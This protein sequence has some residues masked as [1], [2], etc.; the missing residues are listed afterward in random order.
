VG[1]SGELEEVVK[2]LEAVGGAKQQAQHEKAARGQGAP[3]RQL[4]GCLVQSGRDLAHELDVLR[5]ALVEATV[6]LLH[7]KVGRAVDLCRAPPHGRE[8]EGEEGALYGV[9]E[10]GEVGEYAEAAE[11]LAKQGELLAPA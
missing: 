6:T 4:D 9:R 5:V 3:P 8:A 1:R 7:A 11:R 10:E 2:A